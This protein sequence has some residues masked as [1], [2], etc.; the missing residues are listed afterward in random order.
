MNNLTRKFHANLIF[1][2]LPDPVSLG[3][4]GAHELAN[5][6]YAV[7]KANQDLSFDTAMLVLAS[8]KADLNRLTKAQAPL[9]LNPWEDPNHPAYGLS[10]STF[11]SLIPYDPEAPSVFEG[12]SSGRLDEA[13]QSPSYKLWLEFATIPEN[14]IGVD[15]Q[16]IQDA[17]QSYEAAF[18]DVAQF[19]PKW[20]D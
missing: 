2:S 7:I 8:T 4:T 10:E 19:T 3:V 13:M 5:R 1:D 18:P 6:V 15:P 11:N 20:L 16:V 12:I 17:K 14:R 9:K